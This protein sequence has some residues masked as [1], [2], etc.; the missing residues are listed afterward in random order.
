MQENRLKSLSFGP[1]DIDLKT[2]FGIASGTQQIANNVLVRL[3]LD[4]GTLGFGEAAPFPAVNGETQADVLGVLP[5]LPPLLEQVNLSAYR[6]VSEVCQDALRDVP[7]AIAAI[8]M[9]LLDALTKRFKTSLLAFFGGQQTLLHSDITVVTGTALEASRAAKQ[10]AEDGFDQL[11]VKVGGRDVDEDARR[12]LA[13]S[14]AAPNAGL[15]L[16]ANAAY[17]V[18]EALELLTAISS[19]KRRVLVFEQPTPRDAFE[20]LAEVERKGGVPVAADESLRSA[21]DLARLVRVGGVSAVNIKTAKVGLVK[22][23]DLLLSA[24]TLGLSL[25]I[26]GMVETELSMSASACLAAGVGGVKYIDLDTPLFMKERPLRGGYLQH[27]PTLDLSPIRLGHGVVPTGE[28][29]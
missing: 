6:S 26:G 3:E 8:E 18:T 2:P 22:A 15:L 9:A 4:D 20:A 21:E 23:H 16:D 12:L 11:K 5:R 14:A 28:P 27:G 13:I 7:S 25:M 17:N 1:L 29:G 24:K 10:A 19:I